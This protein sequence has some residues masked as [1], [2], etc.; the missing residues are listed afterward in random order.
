MQNIQLDLGHIVA[1]MYFLAYDVLIP[2]KPFYSHSSEHTPDRRI[3]DSV[4][5]FQDSSLS[6]WAVVVPSRRYGVL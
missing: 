1:R 3:L 4:V 5:M 2:H 6:S